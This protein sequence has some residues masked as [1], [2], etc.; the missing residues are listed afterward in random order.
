[1]ESFESFGVVFLAAVVHATLQLSL[2]SLLLLYHASLGRHVR[3]K[4]R[5]LASNYIL[6]VG[7]MTALIVSTCCFLLL[8]AGGA[9]SARWLFVVAGVL[10]GLAF[11][12]WFLYYRS[13]RST[14]LWLPKSVT[15]FIN[16][17]AKVTG[18]NVE[19]F[20]LGLLVSFAEM[21]FSLVLMVVA[22][23]GVV[24]LTE[25]WQVVLA[26]VLYTLVAVLP[27]VVLRV[28]VRRGKTVAEIQK[29][30]MKNKNFFRMLSG[31]GFLT[32][33]GFLIAFEALGVGR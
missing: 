8:A 17:R 27:L 25:L 21:P 19:A 6:G 26:L 16:K 4:T 32:L 18:S 2:G 24:R 30:R 13:G 23:N 22:A 3:L 11:C 1:M 31:V 10:V 9:L 20:S 5:R 33:A 28:C 14:E 15:R 12:A 7:M 29:W